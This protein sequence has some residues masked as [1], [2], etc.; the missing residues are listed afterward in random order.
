MLF[1]HDAR[2]ACSFDMASVGNS[3]EARTAMIAMTTRS[4][5]NVNAARFFTPARTSLNNLP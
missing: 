1:L 3:K 5:I 2:F 4:S